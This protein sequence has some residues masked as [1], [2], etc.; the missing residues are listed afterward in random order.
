MRLLGELKLEPPN[1]STAPRTNYIVVLFEID[2][3]YNGLHALLI[4]M[5]A[6]TGS[7]DGILIYRKKQ[8]T[9]LC[10]IPITTF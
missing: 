7:S 10:F 3:I 1:V 9:S 8:P 4:R 5:F 2:C 6:P